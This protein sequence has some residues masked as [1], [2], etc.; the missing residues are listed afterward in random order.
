MNKN[1]LKKLGLVFV[2]LFSCQ[3]LLLPADSE[4]SLTWETD[5]NNTLKQAAQAQR[6][7]FMDFYT[8][9]CPP[10]KKLAAVTFPDPRMIDY[11]KKENYLLIKV[12]PEKD[13]AAEEKFKV[14]SYPTLIVFNPQG[15]EI[16]RVLGFR[17]AEELIEVLEEVKKGIGTLE[18]LLHRYEKVKGRKT[19]ETIDLMSKIMEKY[20]ARA[21][22]SKALEMVAQ[23]VEA[24]K[25]N[26]QKQASAALFQKGYIY[27]KWKK[28]PEAIEALTSIHKI[29]PASE[30]AEEGYAAAA[31]YSEK[32]KD[33]ALTLKMLR[34]LVKIFPKGKYLQEGLKKIEELE[35][36]LKK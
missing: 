10:C 23:V 16:D 15:V 20:I 34:D 36:S 25:D 13:R 28:Y 21:D 32:L 7:V 8:D 31:F 33:P 26:S 29:Y 27:Y 6:P 12:N 30:E 17:T 2:M 18:D 4:T 9:W 19:A 11:F 5:W 1:N 14:Y 35:K 3:F 22:Y 24:D